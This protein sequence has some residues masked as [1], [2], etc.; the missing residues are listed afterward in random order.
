MTDRIAQVYLLRLGDTNYFKVGMTTDINGR[1]AS[2]QTATP[3][4]LHL[5]AAA[6]HP[7]AFAVEKDMHE[8]LKPCHVRNEWFMCEQTEIV[9]IFEIVS[10]MALI[11]RTLDAPELDPEP[12]LDLKSSKNEKIEAMLRQGFSYRQIERELGVSHQTIGQVSRALRSIGVET[13][14]LIEDMAYLGE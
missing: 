7:N 8:M 6:E 14:G 4:D 3:F 10:A 5:I 13:V 2:L 9:R 12:V 1:V 11:D